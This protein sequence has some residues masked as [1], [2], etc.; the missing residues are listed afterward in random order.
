[1]PESTMRESSKSQHLKR[2]TSTLRWDRSRG[3]RE[4]GAERRKVDV[5]D[6]VANAEATRGCRWNE[7][8]GSKAR[9]VAR[10][11]SRRCT[12]VND[13]KSHSLVRQ[14][15]SPYICAT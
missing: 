9:G 7:T 8:C 10:D 13:A 3:Q 15:P 2:G 12:V 5:M 6:K 14:R 11:V 4:R 1:M